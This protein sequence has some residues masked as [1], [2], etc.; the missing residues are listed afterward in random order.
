[1]SPI[2]MNLAGEEERQAKLHHRATA[3][4]LV[5]HLHLPPVTSLADKELWGVGWGEQVAPGGRICPFFWCLLCL[6]RGVHVLG[7]KHC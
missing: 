7:W 1:M 5:A 4:Q 3:P 6:P 2:L